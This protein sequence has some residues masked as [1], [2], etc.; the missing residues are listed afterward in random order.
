[1]FLVPSVP[2][3]PFD[4]GC[5]SPHGWDEQQVVVPLELGLSAPPSLAEDSTEPY[6][7]VGHTESTFLQRHLVWSHSVFDHCSVAFHLQVH[8]TDAEVGGSSMEEDVDLAV[9]QALA[10]GEALLA[11]RRRFSRAPS[12]LDQTPSQL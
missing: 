9:L 11:F 4:H 1:M 7:L 12:C 3:L 2:S 5:F 10:C 6:D 8:T